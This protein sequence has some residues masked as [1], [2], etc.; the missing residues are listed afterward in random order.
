MYYLCWMWKHGGIGHCGCLS[1]LSDYKNSPPSGWQIQN[2]AITRDSSQLRMNGQLSSM[3]W[4]FWGHSETGPCG[5][6]QGI[7][8]LCILSSPLT[9][10]CL[11]I[12]MALCELCLRRRR[13]GWKTYTSPSRLGARCCPNIMRKS[14]QR[15]VRFTFRHIC[16]I[17]SGCC[18]RLGC[19]TRRWIWMP[20]ARFLILPNSSWPF[21]SM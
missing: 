1:E 20:R 9:M 4:M 12:W 10:T 8:L 19:G 2:T 13:N 18:Y 11:I 17:L 16:W 6:W 5:C 3:S 7:Q 21:W 14:L 15:L